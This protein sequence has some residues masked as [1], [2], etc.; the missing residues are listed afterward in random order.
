MTDVFM[1]YSSRF[2][3][4]SDR[5]DIPRPILPP[6]AG[7]EIAMSDSGP[8]AEERDRTPPSPPSTRS[9]RKRA[10]SIDTEGD[11]NATMQHISLTVP[12]STIVRS[13]NA[14]RDSICLCKQAPKIPRPRNGT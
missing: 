5:P 8:S 3:H 4:S 6:I 7:T 13:G 9:G 2:L 14:E 1:P 10:V 11:S 12:A